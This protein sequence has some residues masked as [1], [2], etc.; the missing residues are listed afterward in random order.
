MSVSYER[1]DN[2]N[3]QFRCD[4][5]GCLETVET[6]EVGLGEILAP[7]NLLRPITVVDG[8]RYMPAEDLWWARAD[9]VHLCPAHNP[10]GC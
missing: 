5:K 10:E 1:S 9:C 3:P 6:M 7:E 8:K 4:A 2:D